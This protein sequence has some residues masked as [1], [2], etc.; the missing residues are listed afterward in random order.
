MSEVEILTKL[1]Q[2]TLQKEIWADSVDYVS[3]FLQYDSVKIQAKALWLLGEIGLLHT[4]KVSPYLEVIAE[5]LHADV[6]LLRERALNALGRIGRG[7]HLLIISFLENMRSLAH[8]TEPNVRLAFI[9]ACENIA[10]NAPELFSEDMALFASLLEDTN[11]RVRIEAPEIFR[12]IG[13]R[14]PLYV[15]PYISKL[16]DLSENDSEPVVRIHAAG[17]IKATQKGA[18]SYASDE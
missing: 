3:S 11:D 5:F 16:K 18:T 2:I 8:D 17:A 15:T 6:S 9:W 13:K 10:V 4:D 7:N 14:K 12:V 1:R